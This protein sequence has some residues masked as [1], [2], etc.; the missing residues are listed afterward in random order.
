[1]LLRVGIE[2]NNDN[3]SI[4]WA[5]EHP[6]CFAYGRDAAEAQAHM[7]DAAQEYAG[8]VRAHGMAWMGGS[9]MNI[10]VEETFDAYHI[11]LLPDGEDALI[12]SFFL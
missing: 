5:L 7:P 11:E 12:E 10:E 2:N 9:P 1:M 6:G 3:R 8:W 4:A